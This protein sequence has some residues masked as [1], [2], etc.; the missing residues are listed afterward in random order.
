M[1]RLSARGGD[2]TSSGGTHE[3]NERGQS[4]LLAVVLLI[5]LVSIGAVSI[6]VIGGLTLEETKEDTESQRIEQ[7]FI[8]LKK[9]VGSVAL[10]EGANEVTDFDIRTREGA[11]HRKDTGRIEVY[12]Q[13]I[14]IANESFGS[15][16]YRRGD[17]VYA[18]QAGGVW[19]GTGADARMVSSPSFYY[20]DGTLNLPIPIVSGEK[21]ISSGVVE[22][23]K[24]RTMSPIN[25]VG[26]VE[27]EMVTVKIHSEY[28]AGWA[29]YLRDHTSERAVTVYHSNQTVTVELGRP[30]LNGDFGQGVYATGG[31]EGDVMVQN[32]DATIQGPV[33]AEGDINVNGAGEIIGSTMPNI[34]S[35]LYEL[36]PAI[37]LKIEGARNNSSVITPNNPGNNITMEGG[38][39]YYLD[40]DIDLSSN[41]VRADLEDGDISLVING[42]ISLDSAD[43]ELENPT[44]DHV[45]RI[46][47]NGDFGLRNG[48][49]GIANESERLQIYGTSD[50]QVAITGGGG[51]STQFYGTIYAPRDAPAVNETETNAAA[52][53]SETKCEGWDVC[54]VGGSAHVEGAIIGG[55]TNIEQDADLIYDPDLKDVEPSLQIEDQLFPPPITFLHVSLHEVELDDGEDD[56]RIVLAPSSVHAA[57][58]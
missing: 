57:D 22:I 37:E 24:N 19:R 10:G 26:Y 48:Q 18:Y 58:A 30:I 4:A 27:G 20:R 50:M 47:M 29:E 25:R 7:V 2:D 15:I 11:I 45:L 54:I 31:D 17:T 44:D 23:R 12:T 40:G 9:N 33:R 16:E 52:L 34:E 55:P 39:T 43:L 46:Y 53:S 1:R 42:S 41:D 35:G 49:A 38:N 3:P 14:D 5:G 6:I 36:D 8:E 56:E 21:R 32:G 51:S 13:N 28:Y